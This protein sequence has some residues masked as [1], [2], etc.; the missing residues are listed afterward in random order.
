MIR[1]AW[2]RD[3]RRVLGKMRGE[4]WDRDE[5]EGEEFVEGREERIGARMWG[6][7]WSGISEEALV[8]MR[9]KPCGKDER[10]GLAGM[11]GESWGRDERRGL[12]QGW[13]E[14]LGQGWEERLG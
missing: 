14:K 6:Q 10:R 7:A 2:C 8:G 13:K 9:R 1:K 12:A 11:R 3:D 4:A 5:R